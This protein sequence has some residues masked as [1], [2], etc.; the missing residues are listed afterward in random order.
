MQKGAAKTGIILVFARVVGE[1]ARAAFHRVGPDD[2]V[3]MA[4]V[5]ELVPE[6]PPSDTKMTALIHRY[7]D[8]LRALD[9]GVVQEAHVT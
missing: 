7:T 2:A 4:R 9:A 1:D 6:L 5:A 3:S 8:T